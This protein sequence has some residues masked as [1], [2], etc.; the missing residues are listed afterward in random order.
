MGYIAPEVFSQNFGNVSY[1]ADVY[2][3]GMLLLEIVGGRKNMNVTT[4]NTSQD[5]Y[6]PEWIYNFLEQK[7]DLQVFIEDDEDE[8]IARKLAIFGL[9]CIQ[10][11]PVDRPSIK[12][13]IQMLEGK[14]DK[15][16]MP[17]NPFASIDNNIARI[18]D[19]RMSTMHL[20]QEIEITPSQKNLD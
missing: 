18:S 16:I 5:V 3:F 19:A 14:G 9:W 7:E 2:S 11:H 12:S 20:N 10:W 1:K 4:E 8:N 17:P 15:F 13:V 6:F